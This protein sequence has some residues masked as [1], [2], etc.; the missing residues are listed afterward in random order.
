MDLYLRYGKPLSKKHPDLLELSDFLQTLSIHAPEVRGPSFRGPNSVRRKLGDIHAHRPGYKGKKTTGS[1]LDRAMWK[2]YVHRPDDLAA[3]AAL[4]RSA[5]V[6]ATGNSSMDEE[7]DTFPEGRLLYG[8]H[9]SRERNPALR[10]RKI[11]QVRDRF[12][13]LLCEACGTNLASRF[14]NPDLEVYECHHIVPL[15]KVGPRK[16]KVSDLALLCPTCHRVAHRSK[17]WLDLEALVKI[18]SQ[19]IHK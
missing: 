15:A 2:E 11:K 8:V 1:K 7:E 18:C 10:Q 9:K 4:L 16:S 12:G 6:A 14:G 19:K 5:S 17:I 3:L 13:H